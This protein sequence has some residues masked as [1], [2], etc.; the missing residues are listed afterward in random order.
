MSA[1]QPSRI[2]S[3]CKASAQR[4][5]KLAFWRKRRNIADMP[6]PAQYEPDDQRLR[7]LTSADTMW[8][9]LREF[10][11][12]YRI[13][14]GI[15]V[16]VLLLVWVGWSY[17]STAEENARTTAAMAVANAK[18]AKDYEMVLTQWPGSEAAAQAL[19]YLA[20]DQFRRE[21]FAKSA[22][23][24]RRFL[25]QSPQHTLAAGAQLGLAASL[26]S[27]GQFPQ[28]IEAYKELLTKYPTSIHSAEGHLGIGRCYE[29]Q[30]EWPKA[31]QA[32]ESVISLRSPIWT[33]QANERLVIVR[34]NLSSTGSAATAVPVPPS[35]APSPGAPEVK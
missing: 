1:C 34:R 28:A 33:P 3:N 19:F 12:Q 18:S 6:Q 27:Q 8:W 25:A 2:Q 32:Y 26:E 17:W 15:G 23:T 20:D 29:L 16:V 30:K 14:L 21:D 35:S 22:E 7:P 5:F 24:Y 9:S 31:K 11:M 13:P 10:A 4:D